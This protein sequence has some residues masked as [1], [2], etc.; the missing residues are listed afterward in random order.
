MTTFYFMVQFVG[1]MVL[2]AAIA[3]AVAWFGMWATKKVLTWLGE[4]LVDL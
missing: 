4:G 3:V 1:S 2:L